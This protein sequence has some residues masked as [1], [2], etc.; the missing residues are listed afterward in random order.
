[1]TSISTPTCSNCDL[2][3][4]SLFSIFFLIFNELIKQSPFI[5]LISTFSE[6]LL[7]NDIRGLL[8]FSGLLFNLF[9]NRFFNRFTKKKLSHQCYLYNCI[10]ISGTPYLPA[11]S[12]G[13][14]AGFIIAMMMFKKNYRA[15][16]LSYISIVCF[17]V[18]YQGVKSGCTSFISVLISLIIGILIGCMW[19]AITAGNYT[20]SYNDNDQNFQNMNETECDKRRRSELNLDDS[21]N[22]NQNYQCAAYKN[23]KILNK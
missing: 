1:M 21:S 17:I 9:L 4:L 18:C 15:V 19:A 6:G 16:A 23:G 13:F 20:D 8:L 7:Y 12:I 14:F 11:Q 10:N 22:D 5:L 2:Q 3:S